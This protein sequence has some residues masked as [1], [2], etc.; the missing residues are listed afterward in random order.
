M[1][2]SY[3]GDPSTTPTDAVRFW[4]QDTDVTNALLQD[5][6]IQYII[7]QLTPL[8]GADP[9]IVASYCATIIAGRYAGEVAITADGVTYS[10]EQLQ[11]KYTALSTALLNQY[12][13]LRALS[14]A[15]FVGGIERGEW[16]DPNLRPKNFGVGM[17]DNER[18]GRQV[19]Y[20]FEDNEDGEL[21]RI[22]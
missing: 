13:Q 16:P 2:A 11:D 21:G 12:N 19:G 20:W 4:L 8:N 9:V 5:Q 7:T 1:S 22:G 18:A 3:S 17:D 6:E 14:G 15:P 10:G